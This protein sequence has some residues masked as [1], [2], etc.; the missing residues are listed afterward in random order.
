[1]F[2]F[3]AFDG[4][5]YLWF[6]VFNPTKTGKH[7]LA[8][9]NLFMTFREKLA[10]VETFR[11]IFACRN[12]CVQY[13]LI[14]MLS[15]KTSILSLLWNIPPTNKRDSIL[16]W[17]YPWQMLELNCS[18]LKSNHAILR[19][20]N[21]SLH[22]RSTDQWFRFSSH[23]LSSHADLTKEKIGFKILWFHIKFLCSWHQINFLLLCFW[24]FLEKYFHTLL[25]AYYINVL[26]TSLRAYL[27]LTLW[28]SM[29][30]CFV[31][32]HLRNDL[33]NDFLPCSQ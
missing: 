29:A 16:W 24:C 3:N 21:P 19:Q 7:L 20:F 10:E 2:R 31:P 33:L 9:G 4:E 26:H 23:L 5:C 1:M 6:S 32:N 18:Q 12:Q 27:H 15:T 25:Y 22:L 11:L 30:K 13:F 17:L 28:W 14:L 8:V